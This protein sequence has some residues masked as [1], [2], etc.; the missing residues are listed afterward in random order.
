MA[1]IIAVNVRTRP[2]RRCLGFCYHSRLLTLLKASILSDTG[3][4]C[5]CSTKFANNVCVGDDSYRQC[6][7]GMCELPSE[8]LGG[9]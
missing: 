1:Y 5:V 3:G 4:P 9:G 8:R 7:N 6:V 2:A